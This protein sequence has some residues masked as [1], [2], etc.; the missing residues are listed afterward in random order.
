[1]NT[2]LIDLQSSVTFKEFSVNLTDIPEGNHSVLVYATSWVMSGHYSNSV[3]S[4]ASIIFIVD[5]APPH[6]SSLSI[7]NKTYNSAEL[8][9]SF[10]VD[11]QVAQA[12]YSIDNQTKVMID[13]NTTLKGLTPGNHSLTVYVVDFA[14]NTGASQTISFSVDEPFPTLLIAVVSVA[15]AVVVAVV[16]VVYL[17]RRKP[18]EAK[19]GPEPLTTG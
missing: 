16:A 11:E 7:E 13:G 8:S 6:I 3:T 9:L 2:I 4:Q 18:V 17:K 5:V 12:S 14:G 10:V 1:M 19:R 15:V